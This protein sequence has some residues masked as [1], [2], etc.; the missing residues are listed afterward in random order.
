MLTDAWLWWALPPGLA[1]V[2]TVAALALVGVATEDR[3]NPTLRQAR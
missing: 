2:C 1:I 3:L